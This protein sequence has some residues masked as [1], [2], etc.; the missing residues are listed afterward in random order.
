LVAGGFDG[1]LYLE[2]VGGTAI[3]QINEN[4]RRSLDFI[5]NTLRS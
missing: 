3:E 1:P 2:C 5:R 4:V